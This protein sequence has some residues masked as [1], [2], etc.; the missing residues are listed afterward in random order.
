MGGQGVGRGRSLEFLPQRWGHGE[1]NEGWEGEEPDPALVCAAG[2][3][4][5]AVDV[6]V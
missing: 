5:G 3:E 4:E 1:L 2:T 6:W